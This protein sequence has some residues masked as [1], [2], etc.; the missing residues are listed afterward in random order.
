MQYSHPHVRALNLLLHDVYGKNKDC[1]VCILGKYCKTVFPRSSTIYENC[2]DL[3][4]SDVGL[5]HVCLEK[6][7]ST[8]SPSL[9]KKSKCTWITLLTSTDRVLET[10]KIFQSYIGNHFNAKLKNFRSDNGGVYTSNAFK[11]HLAPQEIIHQ[12]SC[13]YTTKQNGGAERKK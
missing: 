11:E 1:E 7:R 2:F 8:M 13:P 9:M 12:T 6:I 3:V 10:F 4:H 5:L